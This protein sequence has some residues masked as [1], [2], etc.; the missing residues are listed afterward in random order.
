MCDRL[1][2]RTVLQVG[3]LGALG[4]SLPELL[5][6]RAAAA[7]P[8]PRAEACVVVFLNGGPSHLDMWDMKPDAPAEVRGEFRPISTPVAGLQLSEHLP[9]L[10]P[11]AREFALIRSAHHQ[12][13]NAHAAAVYLA[14]TGDDRGDATVAI[15]AAQNDYP[16]IGSVVSRVYP[17]RRAMVP[18]VSLPYRT[19]EGA[20]GP[21]QPGFYGGW[22]G[23]Q[24][25]PFFILK[26]PNAP[27]FQIPEVSL[28][29]EVP[30]RRVA[31]RQGL[32]RSVNGELDALL[33]DGS[34]TALDAFQ[35]RALDLIS[36]PETREAFDLN[37]E[38]PAT[39]ERYGRN[40]YGQSLLLSRRL[41]QA[42]CRVVTLSWAPDANATWDSHGSNFQRLKETLLPQLDAALSSLLAD[43]KERGMLEKTLVV[44]LGEFG[45]TPK[46]NGNAGRDHWPGCYS[47]LLA[48]GGVRG[49]TVLGRS[50]ELGAFPAENPVTPQDILATVYTLL[51]ISPE[52]EFR[53]R[54]ER[55][56]KIL[57]GT[58]RF[59]HELV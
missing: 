12:V 3:G 1:A 59:L 8:A 32:L 7:A 23:Q 31:L 33:R 50:D 56:L 37:H 36:S 20:G 10:A 28:T 17:P 48:G 25:D 58:G 6:G 41:V 29:T 54:L 19:K 47:L 55:P 40:I 57:N 15:G 11:L 21:P 30:H 49:G 53:D 13:S 2:R 26:D 45:R 51:G 34:L 52:T 5:R 27:D 46:I 38:T 39:R 18:Y 24:Y 4:L 43:L 14:L 42:G 9:R 44:C 16:A 22:M 35:R